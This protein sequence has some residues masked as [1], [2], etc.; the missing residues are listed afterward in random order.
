MRVRDWT[1]SMV[2][3]TIKES[4]IEEVISKTGEFYKIGEHKVH[5][6]EWDDEG[7]LLVHK[8]P[9]V[10]TRGDSDCRYY[11]DFRILVPW[12]DVREVHLISVEGVHRG[13]CHG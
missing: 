3:L 8:Q 5:K 6:I 9:V 1:C 4:R 12:H 11:H 2:D 7:N 13:C 10:R